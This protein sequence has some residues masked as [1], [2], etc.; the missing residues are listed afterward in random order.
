GLDPAQSRR[1][2]GREAQGLRR[3]GQDEAP[4]P[5]RGDRAGLR[6]PREPANVELHHRRD[7][8]GGGPLLSAQ[9]TRLLHGPCGRSHASAAFRMVLWAVVIAITDLSAPVPGL[10][11]VAL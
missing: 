5:A 7:P 6:L 10:K 2:A 3:P 11:R 9:P 4:R 8:A 1:Q